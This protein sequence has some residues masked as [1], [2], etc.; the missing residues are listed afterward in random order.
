M[1][2][3]LHVDTGGYCPGYEKKLG[4]A[5]ADMVLRPQLLPDQQFSSPIKEQDGP[6]AL[7]NRN[8]VLSEEHRLV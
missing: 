2:L 5:I 7:E 1:R 6:A 4:P 8:S 3:D